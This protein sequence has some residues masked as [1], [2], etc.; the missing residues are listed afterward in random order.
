MSEERQELILD[1]ITSSFIYPTM[2][3][4]FEDAELN[5]ATQSADIGFEAALCD[6]QLWALSDLGALSAGDKI[7]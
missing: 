3:L 1:H 6:N 5:P 4:P 2:A 7:T